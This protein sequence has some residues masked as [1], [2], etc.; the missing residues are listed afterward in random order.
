MFLVDLQEHADLQQHARA[1]TSGVSPTSSTARR[2]AQSI[3]FDL[4]NNSASDNTIIV[5]TQSGVIASVFSY[6]T[7][8]SA[9]VA[10]YLNGS[11]NLTF[12]RNIYQ[13]PADTN[14]YWFWDGYTYWSQWQ[15]IGHDRDGTMSQ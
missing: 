4:V 1:T 7:C 12:S 6:A 2:S 3:D 8:T 9:E 11:K 14:Q 5:G 15:S 13:V 10:P